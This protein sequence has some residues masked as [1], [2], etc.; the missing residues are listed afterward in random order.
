MRDRKVIYRI[1]RSRILGSVWAAAASVVMIEERSATVLLLEAI[2][3][4]MAGEYWVGRETVSDLVDALRAL[5]KESERSGP[6]RAELL[7]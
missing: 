6:S 5:T 2:R 1:E 7:G 3:T 4:V